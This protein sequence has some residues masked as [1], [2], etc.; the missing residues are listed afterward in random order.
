MGGR[1]PQKAFEIRD[2]TQPSTMIELRREFGSGE[3]KSAISIMVRQIWHKRFQK[4]PHIHSAN[5]KGKTTLIT[6]WNCKRRTSIHIPTGR[7]RGA[8]E[9]AFCSLRNTNTVRFSFLAWVQ[10][11]NVAFWIFQWSRG[12]SIHDQLVNARHDLKHL[13]IVYVK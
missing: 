7:L 12:N 2:T 11:R 10:P 5:L 1:D 4:N 3:T 8:T 6:S 9:A 13:K